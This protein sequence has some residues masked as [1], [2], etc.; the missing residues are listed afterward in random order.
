MLQYIY[1]N[2]SVLAQTSKQLGKVAPRNIWLAGN[3]DLVALE[4]GLIQAGK[5]GVESSKREREVKKEE[6]NSAAKQQQY[7]TMTEIIN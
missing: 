3:N 2:E 7:N 6:E 4:D 5:L 1:M